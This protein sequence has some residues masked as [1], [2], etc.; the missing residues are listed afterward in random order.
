VQSGACRDAA[1][2]VSETAS[3]SGIFAPK[4]RVMKVD[5]V[6]ITVVSLIVPSFGEG[7]ARRNSDDDIRM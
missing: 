2:G 3:L 6:R 1:L 4:V 7:C 5:I